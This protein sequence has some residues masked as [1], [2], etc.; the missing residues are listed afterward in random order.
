[1]RSLLILLVAGGRLAAQHSE[2]DLRVGGNYGEMLERRLAGIANRRLDERAGKIAALRDRASVAERQAFIRAR[3]LE[4]IG[5]LPAA[6][7]PLNARVTGGFA[8]EG[9]R[10][11]NVI[12]ESLPG[13]KVT[14][15]LY[16]PDP[17][18]M[19]YPAVIG[20][21]GHSVNGKASATYQHAWIG[22]VKRGYVVLAFDP[23]GQ[24][25]R[26][27][28]FDS[29]AG[30]SR[31][32]IGVAEHIMAGVQCLLTGTA[33]ARYEIWDGI[34]AF[35]YLLTRPEVDPKR[36][37]VAGNSG[38]GT[39]TAY[40]AVFEPRLAAAVAS[41]Y[42]TS[43]RQLW[44]GPGPQDAEQVF[45]DFLK[46]GFDFGDFFLA[47]APK[48]FLMT[49][50][51]RDYFPIEGARNTYREALRLFEHLGAS[52]AAGYFEY[53]DTH[54]WSKPRREAAARWLDKHL[55]GKETSGAEPA[56]RTE[57]ESLLYATKTGQLATS[58]GSETVQS[59]NWKLAQEL[60]RSRAGSVSAAKVLGVL[61]IEAPSK[62]P[63]A[64]SKGI[65]RGDSYSIEKLELEVDAEVK[66]PAL[67]GLPPAP[68]G[69]LSG[70]ICVSSNGK[71]A[72]FRAG[73]DALELTRSGHAVL[74]IDPRGMGEGAGAGR[75]DAYSAAY[76]MAA[77]TWLLG[78]SLAGPQVEDV[79]LA[80][81][82]L[83]AHP[84][85]D[86]ARIT[87]LGK[88]SAGVLVVMAAAVEP[89]ITRVATERSVLSYLEIARARIHQ[90][91][92]NLVIPGVLRHFDVPDLFAMISPRPLWIVS[93]AYPNGAV[94]L[95]SDA[96]EAL[97]AWARLPGLR[98]LERPE[99]WPA[100][101][102]YRELLG[103]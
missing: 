88:G 1:M 58:E 5:G 35:D 61:G 19:R 13:F 63:H 22:L 40:L 82:Y 54:G 85:I 83:A 80:F 16:L 93:P 42:M 98:I 92:A 57:P 69:K 66:I 2:A 37:A 81:R 76:R 4:E 53:E 71:A 6:K 67:L 25:E 24:G 27:E 28:Y 94:M 56:I 48:P 20:V 49:T 29:H 45:P 33:I 103:N 34:R 10:V 12:Y 15:N 77:R 51:I 99:G 55:Q 30:R 84:R 8:R 46:D 68:D 75:S 86:P 73:Q 43:W 7:T 23:M 59:L 26:S 70:V 9:Y 101:E 97:S 89:G 44:D 38:G 64:E 91:V 74:A 21:A 39:Q 14:A 36:I 31:T 87:I 3:M 47:F 72:E 52:A 65:I 78:M 79:L 95:P 62:A 90:G 41:C 102:F 50:A 96:G 60:D 100:G 11:E 32:G 17:V 18:R